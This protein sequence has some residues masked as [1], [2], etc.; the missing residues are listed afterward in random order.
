MKTYKKPQLNIELLVA[1]ETIASA[2]PTVTDEEYDDFETSI[3]G[4]GDG[5]WD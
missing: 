4:F 2:I 5:Y 1:E 3:P